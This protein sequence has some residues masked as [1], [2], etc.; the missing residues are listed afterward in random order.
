MGQTSSR[1]QGT[2]TFGHVATTNTTIITAQQ[3]FSHITKNATQKQC[4]SSQ[5]DLIIAKPHFYALMEKPLPN[6]K[7]NDTTRLDR[8]DSGYTSSNNDLTQRNS[9]L[10][11]DDK[12]SLYNDVAYIDKKYYHQH[13][14]PPPYSYNKEPLDGKQFTFMDVY[15]QVY[16]KSMQEID[17]SARRLINLSPNI[18]CFKMI[19][20][21]NIS[22]NLLT[23]LPEAIGRL[24]N[25]EYL[26]LAYNQLVELPDT[27]SHL[28]NLTEL[29]VSH[30]CLV[31]LT[32]CFRI[33][34]KKLHTIHAQNNAIDHL[35][36][37]IRNMTHLAYFN[38]S[39]NPITVLPA[40]VAQLPY[41][42]HML[43]QG[44]PLQSNLTHTLDHDPPSLREICARIALR[45][46]LD[47]S[48]LPDHLVTYLATA[49]PC[50]SCRGPYFENYITRGQWIE[51]AEGLLPL[52]HRLC[53]A[54]WYDEDDRILHM[55]SS[56]QPMAVVSSYTRSHSNSH[57]NE[58][59]TMVV[60]EE[61][62]SASTTAD[63]WRTT[64][65]R[66]NTHRW[67]TTKLKRPATKDN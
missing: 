46:Q 10:D 42:R 2:L 45:K 31:D 30:N 18:S 54:H 60:V 58:D 7:N 59:M 8:V 29:N 67:L 4:P 6:P 57:A 3:P 48:H 61:Q 14:E 43:L 33:G 36:Y 20:R 27:I 25:L 63:R 39:E 19:R 50:T 12:E 17:A 51:K 52:E 64:Q 66:V 34:S 35:S 37:H 55:F 1:S 21:L 22:R 16:N 23:R 53:S 62:S 38:M 44:C 13:N 49:K 5:V 65:K 28:S 15:D 9:H 40:E 26:C 47:T 56:G 41:L 11:G 32:A 24:E